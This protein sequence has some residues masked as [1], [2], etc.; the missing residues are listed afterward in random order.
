MK[1]YQTLADLKLAYKK[2][3]AIDTI[4]D[5]VYTA[6]FAKNEKIKKTARQL[7]KK[8]AANF[9]V[10][11]ASIHDLYIAV[12][13][14]E[15]DGFTVP[16]I[17]VRTL[18]YDIARIIFQLAKEECLGPFIFEIARSEIKYTNQLPDEY[19]TVILA[20]A[21]KE[22]YQGP[23]FLQGDHYQ[24]KA[25]AYKESPDEEMNKVKDLIKK[26]IEAGFYNIDIDASTLVDL[27]KKGF[28]DQQRENYQVTAFLTKYIRRLEPKDITISVGGEIGHIGGK[29]S[30]PE[31]FIAFMEGYLKMIKPAKICGISKI[32]IQTGT[33]HGGI[34]L[35]D[36]RIAKVEI[37]FEVLKKIGQVARKKY[38]IGGAVQHGA[39]TLPNEL[40]HHFVSV[41]TLEIHLATAFQNIVYSH[42]PD[43][44]K[45]EM[46]SW[47]EK[48]L[49]QEKKPGMT[50]KQ[51]IYKTRKKALG[52]FKKHLWDLSSKEKQKIIDDLTKQFKFLFQQLNIVGKKNILERF[53]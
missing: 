34:P 50:K 2:K 4:D 16:A 5:L 28:D 52:P 20:A 29:N 22:G 46:Y 10:F 43:D 30:T 42:L 8:T 15:V 3:P 48:N 24:I 27:E 12:G 17:N 31:D 32:S 47:I 25:S 6:V 26:S 1:I 53:F 38:K 11:P 33:T 23:V 19:A 49:S 40:F 41:K 35:P 39:S 13:H 36:G 14:G 21:I 9:G 45:K 51:F 37:D 7:I 44:L 18:T